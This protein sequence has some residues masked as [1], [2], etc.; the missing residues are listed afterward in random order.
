MQTAKLGTALVI[1]GS[2]FLGSHIVQ[3]LLDEDSVSHVAIVSRNPDWIDDH[4][5]SLHSIDIAS[6]STI[7]SLFANVQPTV[8]IHVACPQRHSPRHV[9]Y[10]AN[11]TGTGHLLDAAK[12]C[13]STKAFIYTSSDSVCHPSPTKQITE[14]EC[15]LWDEAHYN[16][17]YGLTKALADA[18]VLRSNCPDL[19]TGCI[20]V[21]LVYGERDTAFTLQ[22]LDTIEKKQHTNQIGPNTNIMETVYAGNAAHAHVLLARALVSSTPDAAGQA[23]FI[24]DDRPMPFF[25]FVRM[26]Y[27]AAGHPVAAADI[28]IVP[29]WVVKTMAS[30]GEWVYWVG[31]LGIVQPKMRRQDIDHLAGGCWWSLEK[32][33]RVLRYRP[34]LDLD[35]AVR[36]SLEWAGS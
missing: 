28:K 17:N 19:A 26:C 1:G 23:F 32:A 14:A 8:I 13:K 5:V 22:V 2:G 15:Q 33:Q 30:V 29:F 10:D 21:P 31:T 9:L 11:V 24:T 18:L 3:R 25:D 4:R 7:Q 12:Q 27:A 36:R 6:R 16:N 34:V 20:R 35:E